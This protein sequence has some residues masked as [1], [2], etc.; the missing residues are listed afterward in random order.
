VSLS[1]GSRGRHLTQ[2]KTE[3]FGKKIFG[4]NDVEEVLRRLDRLTVEEARATAAHTLEVVYGL[5][6]NMREVI[7]GEQNS[8]LLVTCSLPNTTLFRST[9]DD[10]YDRRHTKESRSDF[11][12]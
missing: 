10:R 12:W 6:E 8:T 11:F 1:F 5:A 7:S 4:D 2:W 3:K 9:G